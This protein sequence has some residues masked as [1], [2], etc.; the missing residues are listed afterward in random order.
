MLNIV[1]LL[2]AAQA[3]IVMSYHPPAA[4]EWTQSAIFRCGRTTLR[5]EGYGAARPSGRAVGIFV[6][7]RPL[8]GEHADVLRRDLSRLSAVYR[9]GVVCPRGD[10][11]VDLMMDIGEKPFRG[12][13]RYWTSRA[14]VRNGRLLKYRALEPVDA[15]TFWFR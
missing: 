1:S 8:K 5:I 4:D 12:E 14:T 10:S 11:A 9:L 2:L 7:D 15:N 3:S 6:N 13:V